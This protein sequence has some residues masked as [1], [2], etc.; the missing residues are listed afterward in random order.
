MGSASAEC[1]V[2]GPAVLGFKG[3]DVGGKQLTLR[4]DHDVEAWCS[5][6]V[7]KNL[8]N[9][10]LRTIPDDR[11]AYALRRRYAQPAE[12]APVAKHEHRQK[13]AVDARPLAVCLLKLRSATNALFGPKAGHAITPAN[14]DALDTSG[15]PNAIPR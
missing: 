5:V 2:E 6:V 8:S 10:S 15:R 12:R 9:Q 4:Y 7:S 1:T 11:S 13:A 3:G 14:V